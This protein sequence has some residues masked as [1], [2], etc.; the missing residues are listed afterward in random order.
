MLLNRCPVCHAHLTLD[1][2]TAD[3]AAHDVLLLFA[4]LHDPLAHA[5]L[6]YLSLW[7]PLK[8]DLSYARTHK[9]AV[10][11]L[12]LDASRSDALVYALEETVQTLRAKAASGTGSL[13]L[14][15]HGYLR[16][17]LKGQT[18]QTAQMS[19]VCDIVQTDNLGNLPAIHATEVVAKP[20][21]V[22]PPRS[23]G[24]IGQ[25]AQSVANAVRRYAE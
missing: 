14:T 15:S 24:A 10:E 6:G 17:V 12:A 4:S 1:A 19:P 11:V 5:L 2:M 25:A 20:R 23:A 7:R 13:P 9:L 3:A 16:Q 18:A 8:R 22:Q 21:R